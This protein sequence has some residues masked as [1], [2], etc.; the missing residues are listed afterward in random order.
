MRMQITDQILWDIYNVLDKTGDILRF[1]KR[2]PI[3]TGYLTG[4]DLNGPIFEKYR[5]D[6]GR[7]RFNRLIYY[8]KKNNYI[9]SENLRGNKAMVLTKKGLSKALRASFKAEGRTKRKDNKWIMLIFDI[10]EKYK[11]S[12]NLMR[13][14]LCNLGYKML[15]QSVWITPFDVSEKT[16]KLLQFYSLDKFVRIFL[17]EKL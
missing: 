9:K 17:I 10:P 14:V 13:S 7:A 8:L 3:M 11:K 4:S 1:I 5:K 6:I 12:R 2:P 16:E 15:Q